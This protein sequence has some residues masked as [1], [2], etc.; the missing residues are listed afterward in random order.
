[1]IQFDSRKI[2]KGDT[3]VAI[4]GLTVDGN[5][6]IKEAIKNGA[7]KVYK[8]SNTL[9]LGKLASDYYK[10]P[11]SKLKL[12]GVTGTKGKTTTCH[13]IHHILTSVGKKTGLI[14][15]I[16][17]EG[18]HTTTP[19]IITLNKTL[20]KMVREN[21]EYVVLEVSSHGIDQGRIAGIKF[22]MS[23]LTNIVPEHLDYHK[24][25]KEYKRVKMM[26]VNSAKYRVFSPASTKLKILEGD[27]NNINAETAIEVCKELGVRN[28]LAI[29]ALKKFH[30][31][32][33]R[34]EEIKNN[35][36]YR[37][38]VDF[39]HTPDSLLA[40]LKYLKSITKAMPAGRQGRL[41]SVFGCAGE[42][43]P[44]KR[45]KMGKI[46]TRLADI[47]IF[48]AEDSRS[49][50]I[51][52]ILKEMKSR[53]I[54]N[55]FI[56]IPERGEA[57]AHALSIVK[58]GDIIGIFGK[59]HEKS[60]C[61]EN[62]EHPWSDQDFIKNQLNGYNN[63]T[64]VILAGGKGKRMNSHLPKIMHQ[65]LGRPM[66]SYSL[67]NLRNAG[68]KK[69]IPVLGYKRNVVLKILSTNVMFAIQPKLLGTGNAVLNAFPKIS[70]DTKNLLVINGDDSAFYTPETIKNVIEL[71]KGDNSV[72]T[73]VS[74]VQ[75]D[76]TGLGRVV[77]DKK[78]IL[79]GIVEEKNASGKQKK[80]KEVN[81]GLYVFNYK[82][83]QKNIFNIKKNTIAREYYLPDLIEIALN[84]KE[85][86]SV[87]TLPD[88][89]EWQGIN[90]QE[91]LKK[92]EEKMQKRILK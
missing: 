57:I 45:S 46:S 58:K 92:G 76:P 1:M 48:T 21:Y 27:F 32:S 53:A 43:D 60:M 16:S 41:I 34:L 23:V 5:D 9:E 90:T 4:K 81:D 70:K 28:E 85:K 35:K 87:Y 73:F 40:V 50:N 75:E 19:D 2:K 83:L 68:I 13:L 3:F 64:G 84:N 62:K 55:K 44:R 79:L 29:K 24:T 22:D 51:L 17:T 36:G 47:S 26:F 66:I 8:N 78:G 72:L 33:G 42:R 56:S 12:I 10:N 82:W 67:E 80:I 63:L 71:H 31:P 38:F 54:K 37:I 59:G 86:V 11:S 49:E 89:S 39:A 88:S 77:R 20:S 7:S 6:Y 14:S 74:L 15:S 61:F 52:D 25:F 65:I 91:E 18:F 30:L 69:I